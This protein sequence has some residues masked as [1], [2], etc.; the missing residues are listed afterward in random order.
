MT[1]PIADMLTRIRN[2]LVARHNSVDVPS[3]RIKA[4]IAKVLKDEGYISSYSVLGEGIKKQI[5]IELKYTPDG[6]SVIKKIERVSRPGRRV[7]MKK[8]E[9]PRVRGGLGISIL[10]TP[11]GVIS[12]TQA[13]RIGVGGELI[14]TIW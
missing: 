12:G 11:K 1:D 5:K 4:D 2:A 10:S 7:Y 3:S 13:R 9:I 14:C 8:D 6:E